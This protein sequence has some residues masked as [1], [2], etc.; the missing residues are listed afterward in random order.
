MI[1]VI[2]RVGQIP[3]NILVVDSTISGNN[4][5]LGARECVVL[6]VRLCEGPQISPSRRC[7]REANARR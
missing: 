6:N 2:T 5:E 7:L 4:F 3:E 1:K